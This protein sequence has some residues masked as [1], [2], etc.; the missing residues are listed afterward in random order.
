MAL[1]RPRIPTDHRL[2]EVAR[3]GPVGWF[4]DHAMHSF[5]CGCSITDADRACDVGWALANLAARELIPRAKA[6]TV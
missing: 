2:V 5:G 3:L 6:P 1:D 4:R